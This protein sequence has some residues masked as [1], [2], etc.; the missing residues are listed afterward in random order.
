MHSLATTLSLGFFISFANN[1]ISLGITGLYFI[2]ALAGIIFII[3]YYTLLYA[4]WAN[5]RF[6]A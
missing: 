1:N 3:K 6:N 5:V 2:N 4:N